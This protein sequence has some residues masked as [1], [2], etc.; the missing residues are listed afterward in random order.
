MKCQCVWRACMHEK[1]GVL[2]LAVRGER[3]RERA[4]EKERGVEREPR[5]RE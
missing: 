5:E 3:E 2:P 1:E 4:R